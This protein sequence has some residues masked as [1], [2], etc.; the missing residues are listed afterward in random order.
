MLC[1]KALRFRADIVAVNS[2]STHFFVMS[3][4]R[5]CRMRVVPVLHNTLW[6]TGFPPA[7]PIARI[8]SR[9][10]SYF[11][12][13]FAA[14]TIGVSPECLRQ[15]DDLTGG[16]HGRVL[17]IR[18]QYSTGV[19]ARVSQPPP[20]ARRPF[21]IIFSGRISRDKGVFDILSIA[22]RVDEL[23]PRQVLWEVC[24]AGP[25]LAEM[26][27]DQVSLGLES[28][29]TIRGW[30]APAVLVERLAESHLAIVP[31]R[32]TF[33]EGMAKT[34]VEAVLSGRPVLTSRVVPALE[35]LRPA[36]IEAVTD[37][38][39]SYAACVV[40]LMNDAPRYHALCEAC[41][42]LQAQFYDHRRGLAAAW[43]TLF[44][45]IRSP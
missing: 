30:T 16:R 39:E 19:F 8:I 9:L 1:I 26:Q 34:A 7:T 6:P 12:R 15:V 2:G 24:G 36:C 29:V 5:L 20:H 28:I 13:W 17:E 3:I 21:R 11:F 40:D 42:P 10:D 35:V 18:A 27:R 14:A 45:E 41:I 32:S 25:D 31:T 38:V 37:D 44:D 43:A 22:R 4:C 33:A 23:V